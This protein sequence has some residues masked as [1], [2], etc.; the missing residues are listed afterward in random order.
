M[1]RLGIRR[2]EKEPRQ[3]KRLRIKFIIAAMSAAAIVIGTVIGFIN[4]QSYLRIGRDADSMI[5]FLESNGGRFPTKINAEPRYDDSD[6]PDDIP[7]DHGVHSNVGGVPSAD[8]L[9]PSNGADHGGDMLRGMSPE[10]PFETRFFTV[11]LSKTGEIINIDT[12]KIAAIDADEAGR[13]A[14][15]LSSEG[16]DGGYW[17][18]YRYGTANIADGGVM[19]IFL[20]CGRSFETFRVFLVTSVVISLAGL[21]VVL[22][23]LVIFSGMVMRPFA[24]IY[25]KQRRFVTDANH[26]LKTPLTV[27]GAACEILEYGNEDE[28]VGWIDRIKE[29]VGRL[30]ELTNKLVFLSKMDEGDGCAVMTDFSLSEIAEEAARQYSAPAAAKE[31]AIDCMI[32]KNLTYCGDIELIRE[33]FSLLFDNAVKYSPCGGRI[34]L[35]VTS[36]GKWQRIII[37]NS[38]EELPCGDLSMLF[39][40]FYRPD[41]SRNSASGGHGIGLSVAKSI[42]E[43][44]RGRITANSPDGHSAVFVVTL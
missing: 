1:R 4:I 31:L 23:L 38:A 7:D 28:R 29:Q 26:E 30:T 37:K 9:L 27:I 15:L 32:E 18:D 41:S 5:S 21:L 12:D 14:V 35:T 10:L 34:T 8:D 43:I 13:V 19:Y 17:G 39:E 36:S 2:R 25:Q 6:I 24:E 11:T 16:R 3:L 42:V 44:H 20:D 33:L 40:R 22:F